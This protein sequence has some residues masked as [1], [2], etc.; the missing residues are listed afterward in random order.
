M[1][2]WLFRNHCKLQLALILAGHSKLLLCRPARGCRNVKC[3]QNRIGARRRREKGLKQMGV[4]PY[5]ETAGAVSVYLV[6]EHVGSLFWSLGWEET[7]RTKGTDT[8]T[9]ISPKRQAARKGETPIVLA[10]RDR[11]TDEKEINRRN[12]DRQTNKWSNTDRIAKNGHSW[13]VL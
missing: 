3:G 1:L 9:F 6:S 4:R 8:H 13:M 12:T 10:T 5:L 7:V 11:L 2:M